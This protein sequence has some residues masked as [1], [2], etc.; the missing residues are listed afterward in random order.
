MGDPLNAEFAGAERSSAEA[1]SRQR[2][3]TERL[4]LTA[5]HQREVTTQALVSSRQA[6][7]LLSASRELAVSLH[8]SGAR[9]A[10][11]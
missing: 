3:I 10:I 9:E 7:F 8:G 11:R 4:L 5:L 1:L 6:T 2:A